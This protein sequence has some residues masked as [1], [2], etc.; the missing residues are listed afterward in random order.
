MPDREAGRKPGRLPP[1]FAILASIAFLLV[2][3]AAVAS[4][5]SGGWGAWSE[6][7][8]SGAATWRVRPLWLAAAV[9]SGAAALWVS[10]AIWG[11]VFRSSGGQ[12]GLPEAAA[13]WIGSN[14]GR[15]LP[16]KIWQVTGLVGYVRA[17]G[18]SGAGALA[19]LMLFQGVMLATG[20]GI[21]VATLGAG[22]FEGI[23][24]WPVLLGGLCVAGA[25]TP[26][27]LQLVVKLGHRLLREPGEPAQ[28]SLSGSV[29]VRTVSGGLLVWILHGLGFWALLEGLVA[30]NPVS[31][32]VATG[33]FTASY[34]LGYLAVIAPGG[35]VVREGAM[36]SLL[37]MSA[38]VLLGPA[39][40]L[41]LAA[42]VWATVAELV[43]FGVGLGVAR[44][45]RNASELRRR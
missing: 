37:S 1:R 26:P 27:V 28:V 24:L 3:L 2:A 33:V 7:V 39:A 6:I 19:T 23:G 41:A 14:L 40:A 20:A 10:G 21:G 45:A 15:Y 22:A 13:I 42:R 35:M 12:T 34:I 4:A 29:L 8:G 17:Q 16:G 36:T 44:S 25:M 38:A 31:P 9:V 18:D 32:I 43:A 30:E 5:L 11:G